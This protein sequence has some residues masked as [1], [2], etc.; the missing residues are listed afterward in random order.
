MTE[1]GVIPTVSYF[2]VLLRPAPEAAAEPPWEEH[3][4]Q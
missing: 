4:A 3:I 1:S 2:L